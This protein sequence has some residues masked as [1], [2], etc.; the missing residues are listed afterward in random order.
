[1]RH[2]SRGLGCPGVAVTSDA[3]SRIQCGMVT[4]CCLSSR[5]VQGYAMAKSGRLPI[6]ETSGHFLEI[7]VVVPFIFLALMQPYVSVG[8]WQPQ[9]KSRGIPLHLNLIC[10]KRENSQQVN[11]MD[12]PPPPHPTNLE[13]WE[14]KQRRSFI[15]AVFRCYHTAISVEFVF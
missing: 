1:M 11:N 9:G 14:E 4:A 13:I 3:E 5:D 15:L 7:R 6:S 8:G 10:R 12:S 2:L